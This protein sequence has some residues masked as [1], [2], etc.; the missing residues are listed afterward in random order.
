VL[1]SDRFLWAFNELHERL[2]R[3]AG[4][5]RRTPF[6]RLV[7]LLSARDRVVRR[8]ADDLKEFADLRN[9]IVHERLDERVI[10]EPNDWAVAQIERIRS[11]VVDPPRVIALFR[12][13]VTSLSAEQSVA[14]AVAAM[15][16]G[17]FSQ[18]PVYSGRDFAGLL[19]EHLLARWLGARARDGAVSL[20]ATAIVE[21]LA[22]GDDDG[23]FQFVHE[24]LT[25]IEALDLFAAHQ[26]RGRRLSA[27]LITRNGT[28]A[29]PLLGIMTIWDVPRALQAVDLRGA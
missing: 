11:L 28:P 24:D 1:N 18:V 29:E 2:A 17:G 12:R 22:H 6:V 25:A 7:D 10:A 5:D 3:L 23:Q 21:A 20:S 26:R 13:R 19:T 8:Y 14:D 15:Y 4:E 16:E 27:L 9:A